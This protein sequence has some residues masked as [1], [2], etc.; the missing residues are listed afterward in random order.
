[1][2][3]TLAILAISVVA[4]FLIVAFAP[5]ITATGALGSIHR[6]RIKYA[7]P[8]PG[9]DEWE[10]HDGEWHPLCVYPL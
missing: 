3:K 6:V 1:M 5:A 4:L 10:W 8:H 7:P 2:K 9:C